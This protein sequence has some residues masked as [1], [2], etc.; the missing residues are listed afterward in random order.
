MDL[1]DPLKILI[2]ALAGLCAVAYI[3]ALRSTASLHLTGK[4]VVQSLYA[5]GEPRA[6]G[7]YAELVARRSGLASF[8]F[9]LLGV[10]AAVVLKVRYS[11]IE[12]SAA[13]LTGGFHLTIPI[14]SVSSI[15]WGSASAVASTLACLFLTL[16]GLYVTVDFGSSTAALA[17]LGT[18]LLVATLLFFL[19]RWK[20]LSIIGGGAETAHTLRLHRSVIEGKE[21]S[22]HD[23]RKVTNILVALIDQHDREARPA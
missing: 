1:S 13:S 8:L 3:I 12:I 21:V 20:V 4:L 6:D 14:R 7:V 17:V 22:E 15:L 23:L 10:D 5:S 19:N 16:V 9:T 2:Q 18:G 11:K